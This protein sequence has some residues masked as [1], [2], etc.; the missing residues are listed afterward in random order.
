MLL[1]SFSYSFLLAS[2]FNLLAGSDGLVE[3]RLASIVHDLTHSSISGMGQY[4]YGE[5]YSSC[6][7]DTVLAPVLAEVTG[8]SIGNIFRII[9]ST[10]VAL[11]PLFYFLVVKKWVKDERIT[12]LSTAIVPFLY[13][14]NF[15]YLEALRLL[16]SEICLMTLLLLLGRY[17]KEALLLIPLASFGVV[18]NYYNLGFFTPLL[19][20]LLLFSPMIL[21]K[22]FKM[23]HVV[24]SQKEETFQPDSS[25]M[26]LLQ[27]VA[28][29]LIWLMYVY[30]RFGNNLRQ[31]WDSLFSLQGSYPRDLSY[32]YS[33][34]RGVAI[35]I[36]Q[37]IQFVLMAIGGL[38]AIVDT[39]RGGPHPYVRKAWM[40]TGF[41]MLALEAIA[42]IHPQ[43]SSTT[44]TL[45]VVSYAPVFMSVFMAMALTRVKRNKLGMV[46]VVVFILFILPMNMMLTDEQVDLR[47][48]PSNVISPLRLANNYYYSLAVRDSAPSVATFLNS[49]LQSFDSLATSGTTRPAAL[50][51]LPLKNI[52]VLGGPNSV[53]AHSVVLTD[54]I[55]VKDHLWSAGGGAVKN[56]DVDPFILNLNITWAYSNG[57]YYIWIIP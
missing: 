24:K 41:T 52:V 39:L 9:S 38:M 17:K 33:F 57:D 47:Y 5:F 15:P 29:T 32:T 7:S 46:F 37:D 3:Q 53:Y 18:S 2:R 16:T 54:D 31:L 50:L 4:A 26:I 10:L 30:S 56:V 43:L 55:F 44:G 6:L 22:A 48:N 35:T 34:P 28:I 51:V 8:M 1:A 42:I 14:L 19:V 11:L 40:L 23:R 45:R 12:Y 21:L 20:A 25:T 13:I 27:C 36:F 49:Y